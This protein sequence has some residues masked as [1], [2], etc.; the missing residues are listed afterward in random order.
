MSDTPET[1]EQINGKPCTRFQVL[2]GDC[3]RDAYVPSEF[4]RKLERKRNQWLECAERLA[5]EGMN[6]M[7]NSDGVNTIDDYDLK[8]LSDAILDFKKLK[9]N[10]Q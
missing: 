6:I 9:Q 8:N 10:E 7:Y 5:Q 3:L 2:G 4:A 1:D